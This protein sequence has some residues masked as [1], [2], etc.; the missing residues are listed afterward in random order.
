M[1][2]KKKEEWV[3]YKILD[4]LDNFRKKTPRT[5]GELFRLVEKYVS[6]PTFNKYLKELQYKGF[7][8]KVLIEGKPY[9]KITKKG[10]GKLE[11]IFDVMD[12]LIDG[13]ID[14]LKK[15]LKELIKT[16]KYRWLNSKDFKKIFDT[17]LIYA[18]Q[19]HTL[20]EIL[21]A[22]DFDFE[23]QLKLKKGD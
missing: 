8:K 13:N 9:Y 15:E 21:K 18:D 14:N 16:S 5:W 10:Q 23:I 19:I 7:I 2:Y 22:F 6:D 20:L 12:R 4:T 11:K 3:K 17:D 1:G